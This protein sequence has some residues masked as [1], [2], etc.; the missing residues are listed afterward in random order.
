MEIKHPNL[1]FYM[2][3]YISYVITICIQYLFIMLGLTPSTVDSYSYGFK[4]IR[5]HPLSYDENCF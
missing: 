4:C 2:M 1:I 3:S 5:K